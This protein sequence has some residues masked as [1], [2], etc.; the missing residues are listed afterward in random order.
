VF[1]P[2]EERRNNFHWQ[3][4]GERIFGPGTVD[5]KGGTIMIWLVLQALST[6]QPELFEAVTWRVVWNAAEEQFSVDFGQLCR[7]LFDE[8]TMA[9]LVF[10][11]EGRRGAEPLLVVA[12]KGR[13]TWRVTVQGRGAHAGGKHRQGANAIVQMGHTVQ[14]IA[15]LTDPE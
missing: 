6:S 15:A 9:A 8:H 5:I 12:R 13:A 4:D 7:S 3:P 14:Q 11:A 2:E 1:P 10:E